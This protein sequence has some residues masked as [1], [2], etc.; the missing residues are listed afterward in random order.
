MV[1]WLWALYKSHLCLFLTTAGAVSDGAAITRSE[2]PKLNA[3]FTGTMRIIWSQHQTLIY[4][5]TAS[6][7]ASRKRVHKSFF[8][9][10]Y[11]QDIDTPCV[12]QGLYRNMHTNFVPMNP[13]FMYLMASELLP[14]LAA[15]AIS[16]HAC[17]GAGPPS[18]RFP[19]L[20]SQT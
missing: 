10:M 12:G 4:K 16:G 9:D 14:C 3:H 15:S 20:Q 18:T 5:C 2:P 17:P 11:L 7:A 6:R 19:Q 8:P 1:D 13:P